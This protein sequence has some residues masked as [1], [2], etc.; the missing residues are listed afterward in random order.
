MGAYHGRA[1]FDV[2]THYKASL[3]RGTLID[4]PFRYPPARE[5]TVALIRRLMGW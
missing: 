5:K 4:P 2:F 3:E 1:S